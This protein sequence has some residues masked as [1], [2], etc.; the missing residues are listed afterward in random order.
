MNNKM[1]KIFKTLM[2][3][4]LSLNFLISCKKENGRNDKNTIELGM[5]APLSGNDADYGNYMKTGIDMAVEDINNN[6]ANKQ[7][8]SII[9]QD[10]RADNNEAIKAF[11]YLVEKNVPLIFGPA[12]S[13]TS[14]TLKQSANDKKVVL[15]SSIST[16]DN[17]KNAG[18]YYFRNIS[19]NEKQATLLANFIFDDIKK[20]NVGIFYENSECG[21]NLFKVF[22]NDFTKKG[23]VIGYSYPYQ[24]NQSDFRTMVEKVKNK[25]VDFIFIAGGTVDGLANII[26]QLRDAKINTPVITGDGLQ[27]EAIN[28]IAGKDANGAICALPAIEDEQSSNYK[29]F[30][31]RYKKK[32]SK[33]PS[34]Y[35]ILSYDAVMNAYEAIKNIKG[36]IT[37]ESIKNELYKISYSGVNGVYRFDSDGEVDKKYGLFKYQ[38]GEYVR[39]K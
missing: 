6:K 1:N 30:I 39:I 24:E 7:K 27:G 32:Y 19:R 25:N 26:K 18:D 8:I 16:A 35:S 9:S 38:N 29:N 14:N 36:E 28:K 31:E 10:D 15:F 3:V 12:M 37:G 5:I 23:G 4:F 22:N 2:I 20:K 21:N 11:N 33:M 34:A 17:L 13:G